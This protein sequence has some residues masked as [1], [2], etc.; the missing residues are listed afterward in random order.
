VLLAWDDRAEPKRLVGVWAL[1][2]RKIA[3]LWPQLLEALPY[4]YAFLSSPVIDL[5][6]VDEVVEAF[7]IA[8][9]NNPALP[10]VLTLKSFDAED[11]S[12][13]ALTRGLAAQGGTGFILSEGARPYA[14]RASGVKRSGSTRK[15]L[16]Q[17]WNRLSALGPVDI[18]NESGRDGVGV[19]FETFLKLE[20]DSWKGA[21]GTALLCDA[22]DTAIVRRLLAAL[23]ETDH[24]SVALLRVGGKPVAAQVLMYCG[25]T[26]Y[27]WKT[28]FD[29]AYAKYSPGA[30]L[31]DK[32]TEE[33]FSVPGIEAINSC[34]AQGSFMTQLWTGRRAM[35][36]LLV[37]VSPRK[38][39]AF[40]LESLRQRGVDQLRA[41]RG[42]LRSRFAAL[43][44]R[45]IGMAAPR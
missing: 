33:L 24:A 10:N 6:V 4:N 41:L 42:R 8:I 43:P 13:P 30:L 34:S 40:S 39:L 36:D 32:I 35:V 15:K 5:S 3:P 22:A 11:P 25:A 44:A 21:R 2:L 28:A 45:K 20:A 9:R 16:R 12:Y 37:D 29:P 27:T 17:D 1:Q 14:T 7:L 19:A 23:A 31:I 18:V 26:A 38:S